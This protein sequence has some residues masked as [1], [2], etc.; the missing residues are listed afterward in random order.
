MAKKAGG[1]ALAKF[2]PSLPAMA[3]ISGV[4]V[5]SRADS[6][7]VTACLLHTKDPETGFGVFSLS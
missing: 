6:N 4:R 3:L 1:K 5:P 2:Y 7:C